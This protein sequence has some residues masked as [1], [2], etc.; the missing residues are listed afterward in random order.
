MKEYK[1]IDRLFQ[2]KFRDFEKNPSGKVWKNIENTLVVKPKR[3]RKAVWLW[4]SGV[5]ASLVI[6]FFM[7]ES[8]FNTTTTPTNTLDTEQEFSN[9]DNTTT[10]EVASTQTKEGSSQSTENHQTK[11]TIITKPIHLQ[12]LENTIAEKY[13]TKQTSD[14][15]IKQLSTLTNSTNSTKKENIQTPKTNLSNTTYPQKSNKTILQMLSETKHK[16]AQTDSETLNKLTAQTNSPS[17]TKEHTLTTS[18]NLAESTVEVEKTTSNKKWAVS[19]V[20]APV[21]LSAFDKKASS[22][23]D[24]F[25]ENVKQGRFSAAYGVQVAYQLN[26][27]F[28]LQSGL[29]IVNYGYKTYGVYVSP[30]GAVS[31]YANINYD[32]DANLVDVRAAPSMAPLNVLNET[33][34]KESK[35]DLTQVF[36]YIEIPI[37][38]K[39]RLNK[40]SLGINLVG[41]FSTLL[42]NKNEIFIE[43]TDFSNK[44]GEASNLNSLNFS[45]NLGLELEYKL[46]KNVNFNLMPMFKAQTNTFE[47]NTAGFSPYAIGVYSGLNLRF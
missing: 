5:A 17:V 45:G 29:H 25:D 32:L 23:D 30:S 42:L 11:N 10:S 6:L 15:K 18:E 43:M 47:K 7:N 44:L 28:S 35:G 24:Q 33:K 1:D 38:A 37:E 39:Y 36:G 16:I 22:I 27:R 40:G 13:T 19:T 20:V 34:I 21:Y 12:K 41:G 9:K 2:E 3:E 14:Q 46:Y 4:L 31:R 8:V 26:T